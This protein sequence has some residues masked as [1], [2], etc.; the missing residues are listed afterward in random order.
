MLEVLNDSLILWVILQQEL[1]E[2]D[3]M[4]TKVYKKGG[5]TINQKGIEAS[6]AIRNT[7]T[8][9]VDVEF[10]QVEDDRKPPSG[11]D[12]VLDASRAVRLVLVIRG[13]L[14]LEL[15]HVRH[16]LHQPD[17]H[18]V[19]PALLLCPFIL[20]SLMLDVVWMD[21]LLL[22]VRQVLQSPCK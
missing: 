18:L 11:P 16:K 21:K 3:R 20:S 9:K 4:F 10:G 6:E 13:A 17:H 15:D 22:G 12:R 1:E 14:L 19:Q 8:R 2:E 7:H 5:M